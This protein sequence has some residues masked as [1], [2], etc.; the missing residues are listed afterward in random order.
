MFYTSFF[1]YFII[2]KKVTILTAYILLSIYFLLIFVL[3]KSLFLMEY[4]SETNNR[5]N[6]NI[7]PNCHNENKPT[8][9]I[10]VMI[11]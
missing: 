11:K 4:H 8:E 5:P 10:E 3:L 7:T 1:W 2:Y 6:N 9:I